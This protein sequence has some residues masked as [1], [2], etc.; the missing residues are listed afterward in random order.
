MH[1][2][3][4]QVRHD[5]GALFRGMSQPFEAGRYHSLCA[6]S[7]S[8]PGELV[9]TAETDKGEIMGV[10][11]RTLAMEG[12]Q[13]H[14]ES[15]LTPEGDVV[16]LDLA[17]AVGPDWPPF[18][19][20]LPLP[21]AKECAI[22]PIPPGLLSTLVAPVPGM[23]HLAR[24]T[25]HRAMQAAAFSITLAFPTPCICEGFPDPSPLLGRGTDE[26]QTAT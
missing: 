18:V 25:S 12:V 23:S 19:G 6:E 8:L 16:F 7:G 24:S 10:R 26:Q 20:P 11:H 1:G 5:D 4:S 9:V 3:T 22:P 21:P 13:F 14:P 15:V 2:K 17:T